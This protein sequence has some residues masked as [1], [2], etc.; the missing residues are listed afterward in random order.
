M[1]SPK[2]TNIRLTTKSLE[3]NILKMLIMPLKKKQTKKDMFL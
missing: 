3:W 2:Q 1:K